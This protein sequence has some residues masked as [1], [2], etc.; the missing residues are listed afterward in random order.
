MTR[1]LVSLFTGGEVQL[2]SSYNGISRTVKLGSPFDFS[3][4]YRGDLNSVEW[5]TKDKEKTALDVLLFIL[6]KN[7][8]LAPNVSQYNG[9][10]FGS[11]NHQSQAQVMFT[12]DP[13]KEVD[14]Q[15]FIFRFVPN[16]PLASDVY[17]TVQLIVKGKNFCYI[18]NC[19]SS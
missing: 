14:N 11:W 15:V 2:E 18:M 17:D 16:N 4:N 5:G 13:I 8:Q 9:R 12:L 10:R 3:W 19:C 1:C 6:D 7:Q